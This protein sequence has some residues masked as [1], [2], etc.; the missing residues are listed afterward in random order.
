[1]QL[2]GGGNS[3]RPWRCMTRH[4]DRR[5]RLHSTEAWTTDLRCIKHA[6]AE[7][8]NVLGFRMHSPHNFST[9]Q[10]TQRRM[11]THLHPSAASLASLDSRRCTLQQTVP[12]ENRSCNSKTSYE[13]HV[14]RP[15]DS[16][17]CESGSKGTGKALSLPV[18]ACARL[19]YW[20]LFLRATVCL[21]AS[22][23]GDLPCVH[24]PFGRVCIAR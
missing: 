2:L 12:H 22:R 10:T 8:M 5:R 15:R 23:P 19:T 24:A 20:S 7:C 9:L 1:M 18:P 4:G 6:F 13:K 21:S 17:Y 11:P 14:L 3:A 16:V